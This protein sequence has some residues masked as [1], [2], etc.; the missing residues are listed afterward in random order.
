MAATSVNQSSTTAHLIDDVAVSCAA[1]SVA[2][3]DSRR[4]VAITM[5]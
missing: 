2:A 3:T 5:I 1:I 4:H